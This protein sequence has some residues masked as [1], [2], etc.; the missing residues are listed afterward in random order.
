M[1]NPISKM[2]VRFFMNKLVVNIGQCLNLKSKFIKSEMD[3]II[4]QNIASKMF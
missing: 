4:H 2:G 1:S 3:Q